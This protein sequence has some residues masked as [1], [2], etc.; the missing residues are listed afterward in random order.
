MTMSKTIAFL[1]FSQRFPESGKSEHI[2]KIREAEMKVYTEKGVQE[3]ETTEYKKEYK[4]SKQ[5]STLFITLLNTLFNT[6]F[7]TLSGTRRKEYA[8]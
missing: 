2:I 8:E 5:K 3:K 1:H 6:L 7:I 4:K